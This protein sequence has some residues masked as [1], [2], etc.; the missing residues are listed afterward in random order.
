MEPVPGKYFI[1]VM[2]GQKEKRGIL[3]I[4]AKLRDILEREGWKS[5]G[6]IWL[7]YSE[8]FRCFCA[9][10][11]LED[12][13]THKQHEKVFGGM[14]KKYKKRISKKKRRSRRS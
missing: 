9:F 11:T 2:K 8:K 13:W 4:P 14:I 3:T 5:K 7:W 1:Q 6:T 12:Y 10:P